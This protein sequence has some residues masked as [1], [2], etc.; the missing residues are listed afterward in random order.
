MTECTDKNL[1]IIGGTGF[2]GQHVVKGA[3]GRSYNTTVLSL[4]DAAEELSVEGV[5]YLTA[6]IA[7][8]IDLGKALRNKKFSHVVNLGGY[9]NHSC[10]KQGGR[11]VIDAHFV[12]V[13]NLVELLDWDGL[14]SFVQIGSSDEYGDAPAPQQEDVREHPIS[15]YSLGKLAA[16]HFLQMLHRTEGFP[17]VI[18]RLFLVYGPGQNN[19]RFLPQIISGCLRDESFATSHGQQLRDFCYIDDIVDGIFQALENPAVYGEVINLASGVPVKIRT[20]L[21]EVMDTV[22]CGKPKFGEVPYRAGENMSLYADI[23]KARQK[24]LWQPMTNLHDGIAQTVAY[25]F[26][27]TV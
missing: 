21:E 6:N 16:T 15:P 7:D 17:A 26:C 5:R 27:E 18:L 3:I 11:K 12:G 1:L 25:Y 8:Y 14:E 9:I 4:H 19:Q 24:L 13:E 23:T 20:V 22:G 10:Y 2:I